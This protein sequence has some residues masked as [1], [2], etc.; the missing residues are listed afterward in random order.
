VPARSRRRG[1]GEQRQAID[2]LTK[3]FGKYALVVGV[4]KRA[5]ELKERIDSAVEP[6]SGGLVNRAVREIGRGEVKIRG[7]EPEEEPD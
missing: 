6:S 7:E 2:R 1:P 4:A 3:R 5:Q